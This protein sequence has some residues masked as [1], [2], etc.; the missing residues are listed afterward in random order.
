[1]IIK[2]FISHHMPIEKNFKLR[3][4]RQNSCSFCSCYYF[5]AVTQENE[6]LPTR[7]NAEIPGKNASGSY[8]SF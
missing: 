5:F 2:H 8:L 7:I 4:Q 1:M 3:W 6:S